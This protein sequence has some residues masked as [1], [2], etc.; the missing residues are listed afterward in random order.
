MQLRNRAAIDRIQLLSHSKF[1]PKSVSIEVGDVSADRD[2]PDLNKA[3]FIPV[4]EISFLNGHD[5]ESI[6]KG[7]QLQTIEF[8]GAQKVTFIKFILRQNHFNR[9]NEYNQ[10]SKNR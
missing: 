10:V 3:I 6:G 7:R 4:G 8:G 9:Q 1:I 5:K 2:N